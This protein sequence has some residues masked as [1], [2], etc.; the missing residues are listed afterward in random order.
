MGVCTFLSW[1]QNSDGNLWLVPSSVCQIFLQDL[2]Q[3]C[4][5]GENEKEIKVKLFHASLRKNSIKNIFKNKST[6]VQTDAC[7]FMRLIHEPTT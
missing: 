2:L 7:I 1:I 5:N 6:A 4:H 3:G